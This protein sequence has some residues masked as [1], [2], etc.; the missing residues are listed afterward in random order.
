[1]IVRVQKTHTLHAGKLTEVAGKIVVD[2][3]KDN[4]TIN[5]VKRIK[6]TGNG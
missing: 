3:T 4:L 5:C 1:M 2:A 6:A